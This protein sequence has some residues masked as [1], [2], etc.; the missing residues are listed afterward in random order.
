MKKFIALALASVMT[1]SLAACG[2]GGSD[3]AAVA[4]T[5]IS[6]DTIK[7]GVFEPTTG[8]NGGG[9]M[10]EVLGIRYANTVAPTVDINGTTYNIELVE[11]DNQSDKTAA[12]TAA[13]SLI[14]SGVVGV[15]GS[16]G[17]GVSIAAGQTYAEAGVPAIGCSCTNPQVTLGNDFYFRTCF[18]D[19]FQG[20]VMASYAAEEMGYKTAAIISQNGDDY[21]TGIAAYFKQAFESLGGTIVA[22]ET[23]QTN[24]SDFNAILTTV[25]ASAAECVFI[26]CS[27]A[28]ATLILPQAQAVGL[29]AHILGS[30]TW[31]NESIVMAAGSAAEGVV[32]STFFDENDESTPMAKDFV[33]GFKAYL[34]EDPQRV[35]LNGGT[36][37]V[38][39]VSALGY[40]AYM[41]MVAALASLDGVEGDLTSVNLRDALAAVNH[42][43]VTGNITFDET[44]DANKDSAYLKKVEGGKFV[45]VK[46]QL[47]ETAQ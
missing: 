35:T 41:T 28:T 39:A 17:S 12:V 2:G 5:P 42:D 46:K 37:G 9:G 43:G 20:T 15:L 6:G 31:E 26:P 29:D 18:L 25:K 45:F 7:I 3:E 1:F 47:D 8:E 10:Q 19:P 14:S 4:G 32:F 24:E 34:N 16:Y 40:D 33:N 11:V 22:D 13:Q 27:I 21:S 44:G 30:D 38:A 23:Y 36:D